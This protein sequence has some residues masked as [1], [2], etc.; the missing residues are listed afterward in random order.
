MVTLN[1]TLKLAKRLPYSMVDLTL[2]TTNTLGDWCANSFN[3]GRYPFVLITNERTL[4][5][6]VV[7]LKDSVTF[8]P[9]FIVS[10][11]LLLHTIGLSQTVIQRELQEYRQVQLTRQTNRHTL[12]SMNDFVYQV[13]ARFEIDVAPSLQN[14]IYELSEMP[15]GALN[16]G[17]PREAVRDFLLAAAPKK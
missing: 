12:G 14:I 16:Y 17:N 7:P 5:S 11:E 10:L 15:S 13:R 2:P 3:L 4:L 1:C 6:V 8:W 9:R